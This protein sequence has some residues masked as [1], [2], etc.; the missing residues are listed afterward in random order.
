VGTTEEEKVSFLKEY[1]CYRP[2]EQDSCYAYAILYSL[3]G[4]RTLDPYTTKKLFVRHKHPEGHLYLVA[5]VSTLLEN[6][7]YHGIM[8]R[9]RQMGYEF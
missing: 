1:Y 9:L 6:H 7:D 3:Y 4:G 5:A 8:R 2:N